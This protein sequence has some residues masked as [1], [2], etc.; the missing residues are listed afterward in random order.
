MKER[1]YP[2]REFRALVKYANE[3]RKNKRIK[4]YFNKEPKEVD[5]N[6]YTLSQINDA[7]H[8]SLLKE[9]LTNA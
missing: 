9:K 4:F 2:N 6:A 3:A 7:K 8:F 5:W 1:G